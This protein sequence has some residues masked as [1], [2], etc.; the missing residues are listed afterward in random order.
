MTNQPKVLILD[1]ENSPNIADVWG[2]FKQNIGINQLRANGELLSFAAKWVGEKEAIF[3]GRDEYSEK[4]ILHGVKALINEADVVVAHN[5]DKHDLPWLRTRMMFHKMR[6]FSP[7]KQVDTLKLAKKFFKLPSN[8]LEFVAEFLGVGKKL[9]H[10]AFPGHEL[11]TECMKNNPKAWAEMKRYNINDT[12]I[13][14]GVYLALR[15][16]VNGNPNFGAMYPEEAAKCPKCGSKH[17]KR[18]GFAYTGVSKFQR[19]QCDDCGG[20]SRG[21]TNLLTKEERKPLLANVV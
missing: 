16:W 5:G 11:W 7:V 9:K 13:L 14:E 21:R 10:G 12:A 20:W 4:S 8:K 2:L 18:R 3:M 1:I 19:Y 6:P 15:P 17:L